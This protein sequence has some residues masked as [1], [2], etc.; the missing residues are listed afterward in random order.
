MAHAR[1]VALQ[2]Q[3]LS[4]TGGSKQAAAAAVI[5]PTKAQALHFIHNHAVFYEVSCAGYIRP[6]LEL[7]LCCL[8]R[9]L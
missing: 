4:Q 9:V 8:R 3:M 7:D 2:V 6:N 5:N 1:L